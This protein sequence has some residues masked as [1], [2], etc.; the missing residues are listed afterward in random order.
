[1]NDEK[2]IWVLID[3]YGLKVAASVIS[4]IDVVRIVL[5]R[6]LPEGIFG[7]I[8]FDEMGVMS[9]FFDPMQKIGWKIVYISNDDIQSL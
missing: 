1:M 2:G 7:K 4:E 5:K 8:N 6:H 3:P 9:N